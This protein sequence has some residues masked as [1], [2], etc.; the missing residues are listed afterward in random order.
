MGKS[1]KI[2][3]MEKPYLVLAY[4][5]F[6]T[7][8]NPHEEV[9]LHKEFF[10]GKDA[11]SR[12]YISEEGING[13]MSAAKEVAHEYISWMKSRS[14]FENLHF[15]LHQWHEQAFPRL[16]IKYRKQL[17]A[18]DTKVDI[19]NQGTHVS[20][21]E[22]KEL[23]EREQRPLLL[24]VRNDY[25]WKV[26][27]FEGAVTPNCNTFREFRE[28]ADNLKATCDPKKT[29]VMMYCTGGIRCE[30][31]SS[32]L[33]EKGFDE[34]YQLNGGVI[35]YGL[36]EG[37]NHWEGKLYVFDDR[38][39]VPISDQ[40]CPKIGSCHFC[41][42]TIENYYNCANMDCNELFLCCP[43]CLKE[44]QGCCGKECSQAPRLRSYHEQTPHK[45][46]RRK[47][48]LSKSSGTVL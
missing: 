42:T 34:V 24:D 28:Y 20:P 9:R 6:T 10:E 7:I 29:P 26:G 33:K 18:I 4:Y 32:L 27:R 2:S 48:E 21:K 46:F 16:T 22:W 39:V 45:P 19:T 5:T 37:S 13:Q 38:M 23:L 41:N 25:E 40:E 15:K 8:S 12:I 1:Y 11:T 44:H 30:V 3:P 31:Y 47:S 43:S 35:N 36:Q 17:V 14:P